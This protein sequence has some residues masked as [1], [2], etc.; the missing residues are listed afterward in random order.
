M[1]LFLHTVLLVEIWK[2]ACWILLRNWK[3]STRLNGAKKCSCFASSCFF[4][5]VQMLLWMHLD[6]QI[7]IIPRSTLS[8]Y[9]ASLSL[10]V[11]FCQ[12]VSKFRVVSLCTRVI[13]VFRAKK[14]WIYLFENITIWWICTWSLH[15][16]YY[17]KTAFGKP[18]KCHVRFFFG[19]YLKLK[20]TQQ[21]QILLQANR[22][23][24]N[25]KDVF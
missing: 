21:I 11:F 23:N 19:K 17:F 15:F 18:F 22:K 25:S 13:N 6:R 7:L 3:F 8:F 24:K 2:W 1:S 10:S 4:S 9:S 20:K 5:R 12:L 14:N 16:V